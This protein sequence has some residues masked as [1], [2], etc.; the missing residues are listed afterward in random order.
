MDTRAR[1]FATSTKNLSENSKTKLFSKRESNCFFVHVSCMRQS[2]TRTQ[3]GCFCISLE[4]ETR[5]RI[6]RNGATCW[7]QFDFFYNYR[8]CYFLLFFFIDIRIL[9]LISIFNKRNTGI[10]GCAR[11][12]LPLIYQNERANILL[13]VF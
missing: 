2:Y 3:K 13:I 8:I 7:F 6:A 12:I 9:S 11:V 1:V 4:F 5:K 10:V